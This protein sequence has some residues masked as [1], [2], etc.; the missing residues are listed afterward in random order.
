MDVLSELLRVIKLDGALFFRG[1]FSAPWCLHSSRSSEMAPYLS[2]GAEHLI[3]FHLLTEGQA[4]AR[5]PDGQRE[6]LGP[7]DIVVLPH[8]DAHL[9]GH[10]S[11]PR[12]F[13]SLQMF[14]KKLVRSLD[15]VRFG[16]WWRH[17]G[18]TSTRCLRARLGGWRARGIQ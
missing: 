8:G 18:G 1:E 11:P 12:A 6:E 5:L 14:E 17:C 4:Y 13:E 16:C 7:G 9:L 15:A 2:P 10:G 3:I